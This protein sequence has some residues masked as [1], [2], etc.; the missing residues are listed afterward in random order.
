ME[1]AMRLAACSQDLKGYNLKSERQL[2]AG[3]Q[4][5]CGR[6][7]DLGRAG[8][9]HAALLRERRTPR[10]PVRECTHAIKVKYSFHVT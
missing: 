2:L 7:S 9:F 6:R 4:N 5:K 10:V 8:I 1:E 3:R